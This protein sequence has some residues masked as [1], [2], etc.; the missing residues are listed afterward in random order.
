[1]AQALPE[2]V[3]TSDNILYKVKYS[4]IVSICV[5]AIKEQ[6]QILKENEEKLKGLV[7][8]LKKKKGLK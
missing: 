6:Q 7:K 3:Y 1:L 2:V 5:Q 8:T 4:D